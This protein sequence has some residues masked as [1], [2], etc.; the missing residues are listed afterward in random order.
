[1]DVVDSETEVEPTVRNRLDI[2]VADDCH[3]C[4]ES[5]RLAEVVSG[6]YPQIV[7]NI[8]NLSGSNVGIPAEV[9]AVPTFL[10]NGSVLHLGNPHEEWLLGELGKTLS[11][12]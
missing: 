11:T 3:S 12:N 4:L 10:L 5:A 1:M 6:S 7:V 2:Y 9:V 8:V